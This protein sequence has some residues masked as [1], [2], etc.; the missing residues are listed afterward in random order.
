MQT[1]SVLRVSKPAAWSIGMLV[2]LTGCQSTVSRLVSAPAEPAHVQ[3]VAKPAGTATCQP[4]SHP[5]VQTVSAGDPDLMLFGTD[6]SRQLAAGHSRP[7]VSLQQQ[8]FTEVGRDFDPDVDAEGKR[9]VFASTRHSERPRLYLQNTRGK[10]VTQLT[11]DP[12]SQIQ[13]RFSPDGRKIAFASDRAGQ[14]DIYVLDLQART[15]TQITRDE[16]HELAP[17]WSPD[18]KWLA[19]S[20]LSTSGTWELWLISLDDEAERCIGPGLLPRWSPDGTH[21]VFQKPRER[22]G[23]LFGIW[24]V[25]IEAGEPSWPTEIA[26]EP[27]AALI[28][29]AWSADGRQIA[30]CRVAAG[31]LSGS[32]GG[33]T[34]RPG[35]ADIYVVDVDGANRVRLTDGG[36]NFGPCFSGEGRLFFSTDRDG[37]ERIWSLRPMA[38]ARPHMASTAALGE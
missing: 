38:P 15:T 2:I 25:R 29:P 19:Y 12:A 34:V 26:A 6:P 8:S 18:G 21:L 37:R 31:G 33:A 11:H 28:C 1:H 35:Q 7:V 20:R 23:M 30:F 16:A 9:V 32:L 3:P 24:T 10:A 36:A 5:P 27:D 17:S 14:W 13:P 4:A 22:D